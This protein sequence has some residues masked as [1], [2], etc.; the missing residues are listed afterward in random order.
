MT[1]TQ[2]KPGERLFSTRDVLEHT[3]ISFR[4]LDYWLRTGVIL[5]GDETNTPG[6]GRSRRYTADEMEAIRT[7]IDRY[8]AAIAEVD[9]VRSGRAWHDAVEADHDDV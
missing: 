9:A 4:V 7:V 3:G 8:R 2:T 5:L 1:M 6:S